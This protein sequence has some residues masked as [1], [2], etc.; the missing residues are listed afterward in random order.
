MSF[1][2]EEVAAGQAIY[3]PGML[4]LYDLRVLWISNRFIWKCPTL[5]LL[6]LYD[7]RVMA[8]HLDVGVGSGYCLD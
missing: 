8:N 2:P 1:T 7:R 6:A 5:R 4:N 3:T